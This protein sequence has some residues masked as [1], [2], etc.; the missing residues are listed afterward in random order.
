MDSVFG[1]LA[2]SKPIKFLTAM[3]DCTRASL[4]ASEARKIY[5]QRVADLLDVVCSFHGHPSIIRTDQEPELTARALD[6][7]SPCQW[8]QNDAYPGEP[9]PNTYMESL[10]GWVRD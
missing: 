3:D 6:K 2:S 9:T 1:A 4:K 5:G 8:R 10:D 7:L